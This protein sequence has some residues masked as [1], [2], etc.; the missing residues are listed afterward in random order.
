MTT[1]CA[2]VQGIRDGSQRDSWP[3]SCDGRLHEGG[4]FARW[5]A[6][7]VLLT[8]SQVHTWLYWAQEHLNWSH[9]QWSWVFF[10]DES[11]FDLWNDSQR[12]LV[13]R[14][15]GTRYLMLNMVKSYYYG[16][17][18]VPVWA[19][20]TMN[21]HR[22]FCNRSLLLGWHSPPVCSPISCCN[23]SWNI[24][25]GQQCMSSLLWIGGVLPADGNNA[26]Y[27]MATSWLVDG[28]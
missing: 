11:C 21:F 23:G 5:P 9:N 2:K 25:H 7:C 15:P 19:G 10:T 20:I 22:W 6:V 12:C 1:S 4:L 14:E 28:I 18:G 24:I 17:C 13:W 26:A 3:H 8:H 16:G 27:A